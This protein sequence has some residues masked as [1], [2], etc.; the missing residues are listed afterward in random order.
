M[1]HSLSLLVVLSVLT[2]SFASVPKQPADEAQHV[3]LISVDGLRPEFY[4]DDTWPAPR[5]QQMAQ[6][7][8]AAHAVRGVFPTVTYPSHTTIITGARPG[9]HGVFYN[10]PFEP[11]GQSGR[12][13]WE[14]EAIQTATL[15]DAARSA[16]MRTASISW[17][18]SVDAPVDY[19]IPE[20]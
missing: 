17:P 4:L 1:Q 15:W 2:G 5:M 8:V 16:G 12:W 11:G 13:Y 6:H 10:T 9:R 14:Y 18:V 7:G 19:L 3:V 20:I